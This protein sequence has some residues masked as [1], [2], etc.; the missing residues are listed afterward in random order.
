MRGACGWRER[1]RRLLLLLW[2][3][4]PIPRWLRSAYLWWT[5]A[6][7]LVG[8]SALIVNEHGEV[9]LIKHTYRPRHPWGLPGGWLQAGE[10]PREGLARELA[11]ETGLDVQVGEVVGA[12]LTHHPRHIHL[13]YRVVVQGGTFRPS[14]EATEMA[15]LLPANLAHLLLP[16][17]GWI[18]PVARRISSGCTGAACQPPERDV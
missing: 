12:A 18:V 16:E 15:Y 7:F 14:P 6:R 13:L 11:E 4:L 17:D 3:W 8:V 1:G 10:S 2:R 9:L 5:N